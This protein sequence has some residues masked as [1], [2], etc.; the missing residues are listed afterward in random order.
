MLSVTTLFL[1]IIV[2]KSVV[3]FSIGMNL[4][5]NHPGKIFF[6]IFLVI[7]VALTAPVGGLIGI[8]L[9]GA[10]IGEQ[11][12]N[13]VTAVFTSLAIGTFIY[14]TFFE[15]LYEERRK[16]EWKLEQLC[17]TIIGFAVIAVFMLYEP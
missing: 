12:R 10:E 3:A 14:I 7:I 6:V 1:G 17:S 5:R 11:P 8:A 13:I 9:E 15:I 4:I 16:E 2:H